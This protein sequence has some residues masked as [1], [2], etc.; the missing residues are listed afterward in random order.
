M[1]RF[2]RLWR[3]SAI[4]LIILNVVLSA[5]WKNY[6]ANELS[7]ADTND[8][9]NYA[10]LGWGLD[11]A[12]KLIESR[13]ATP[14]IIFDFPPLYNVPK[15]CGLSRIS[16]KHCYN[17]LTFIEK[18]QLQ[19]REIILNLKKKYKNIILIDPSKIIC[20]QSRCVSSINGTP[21]YWSGGPDSHLN[22]EGSQL[23]GS[24]YL[25]KFGNPFISQGQH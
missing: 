8:K 13:S 18:K 25:K 4:V 1:I 10:V 24:L 2:A 17:N 19:T 3:Y 16:L 12:I 11:N 21:L 6:G 9:S 5:W 22:A 14:V 23:I 7:S 15:I 20:E